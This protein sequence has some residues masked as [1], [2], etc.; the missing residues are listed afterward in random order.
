MGLVQRALGGHVCGEVFMILYLAST[1][2]RRIF[3]L[4]QAGF[5]VQ[6]IKPVYT[7]VDHKHLSTQELIKKHALG[8]ALSAAHQVK[9]GIL[10]SADTLVVFQARRIG[11]PKNIKD[12]YRILSMLQGRTHV[13]WT[14]VAVLKILGGNIQAQKYFVVKTKV[15]LKPVG[16]SQMKAYFKRI[17]PLDKAGAYA[18]QAQKNSIVSKVIGSYTNAVGLPMEK[19]KKVLDMLE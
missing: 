3:L 12:A 4:K 7:E 14:G 5:K 19:L 1:S 11:K 2:P 6:K 10:V 13:V 16:R 17:N 18:I 8:K 15:S 9:E